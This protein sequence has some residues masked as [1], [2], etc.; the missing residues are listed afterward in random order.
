MLPQE[1][2][3]STFV[4]LS[5]LTSQ[6]VVNGLRRLSTFPNYFNQIPLWHGCMI[7]LIN[8][9][10]HT[11]HTQ[12]AS[13]INIGDL[14]ELHYVIEYLYNLLIEAHFQ[15][16]FF[17]NTLFTSLEFQAARVILESYENLL[18]IRQSN[19]NYIQTLLCRYQIHNK[20]KS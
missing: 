12:L 20:S 5:T 19:N 3:E 13:T 17:T 15:S 16:Y 6:T 8:F 2:Q 7:F 1:L 10:S 14:I 9:E 4:S 18:S 11:N